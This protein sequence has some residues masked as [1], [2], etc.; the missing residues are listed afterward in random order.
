M[1]DLAARPARPCPRSTPTSSPST[2][3]STLLFADGQRA[4]AAQRSVGRPEDPLAALRWVAE[5][6]V[7]FCT[8]DP[9]RYQLLF[10]HSVPGFAPSEESFELAGVNLEGTR[11]CLA[12][13]G[14]TCAEHLDVWTALWAGVVSQQNANDP[15][16]DRWTQ[17]LD[18]MLEMYLRQFPPNT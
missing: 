7:R 15:G 1:R 4:F 2:R 12:A 13:V 14:L 16:G 8:E 18:T 3:S 11:A 10:Q 9:V 17:H 6:F 5:T